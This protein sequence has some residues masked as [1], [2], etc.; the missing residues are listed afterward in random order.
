[1]TDHNTDDT[2][3]LARSFLALLRRRVGA[4][5][6]EY[7]GSPERIP[8]GYDTRIFAF[9]LRGAPPELSGPLILRLY[10]SD[11]DPSRA[12]AEAAIH[13]TVAALGYPCPPALLVGDV[14][15][16]LAGGFLVLPR[17]RGHVL[18]DE[19]WGPG[20]LRM[21]ALLARLHMALH[22]LDPAPLRHALAS[23]GIAPA[24]LRTDT[25]LDEALREVAA[26]R[27]DGLRPVLDWL[28][29]N[30][31][32][33]T[34]AAVMCHGDFHPLNVLVENGAVTGV[35]DWAN[36][37]FGEAAYDVGATIALLSNGPVDA[38]FGLHRVVGLARRFL[39]DAYRRAYLRQSP[40]SLD[41]LLYYEALRTVVFVV[42][43]GVHH[44][45]AAGVI[46]PRSKPS[47]FVSPPVLAR[48]MRRVEELTGITPRLA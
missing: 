34:P 45:A 11:T 16:G 36:L 14:S 12:P 33:E 2:P 18:L 21:P 19:S 17:V 37:R 47:A 8:G 42:E 9:A 41:R 48:A 28:V 20:L 43:A 22:A 32:P 15:D 27:L 39:V 29:A 7:A 13:R 25:A 38:P 46:P 26:A 10:R 44:R 35:I 3:T 5:H 4:P 30:R 31:P 24:R 1:M 23:A 6:L 40:L